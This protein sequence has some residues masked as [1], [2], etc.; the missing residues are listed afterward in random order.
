MSRKKL[1]FALAMV[2][3]LAAVVSLTTYLFRE[4]KKKST[5]ELTKFRYDLPHN[6]NFAG[7]EIPAEDL[8]SRALFDSTLHAF[9]YTVS[10]STELHGRAKQWFP[11]IE[12]ILKKNNVPSDF[13]YVALIESGFTLDISPK[14]A[15]GYWQFME[16]TA[17]TYGLTVNEEIDERYHLE[18]STY[19]ACRFFKDAYKDLK[20]WTLTA[21]A[22]NMGLPGLQRQMEKQKATSYY[23]MMLNK[24]TASYVYRVLALKTVIESPEKYGFKLSRRNYYPRP[25]VHTVKVDSTIR[26]LDQFALKFKTSSEVIRLLNPWIKRNTLTNDGQRTF[27]IQLPKDT[28]VNNN[29]LASI[30]GFRRNTPDSTASQDTTGRGDNERE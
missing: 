18:K 13:K 1:I 26:D 16:P 4:G 10:H 24:E 20:S 14:G 11:F 12:A 27:V 8:D 21:A 19:A 9:S 2:F 5:T 6:L 22:F 3:S 29:Y 17:A 7:E 25:N 23:D 15:Q 28:A 30:M